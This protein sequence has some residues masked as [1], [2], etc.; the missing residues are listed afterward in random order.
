[1]IALNVQLVS[2]TESEL[3]IMREPSAFR[4]DGGAMQSG[5]QGGTSMI[6]HNDARATFG[7]GR[8]A[9]AV[10][11]GLA[12]I[13]LG[14][15]SFASGAGAAGAGAA[16]AAP[17]AGHLAIEGTGT[18]NG[19]AGYYVGPSGGL[20]SAS[21]TFTVPKV[22]CTKSDK[23]KGAI[24]YEGVYTLALDVYALVGT[25]CSSTGVSD[26]YYFSTSA[27]SFTEPGAAPGDVVV[28]SVFES[29][30]ATWAE[31][32]DLTANLYW[33]ANNPANQG[34]TAVAIGALNGTYS[35]VPVPT[36]TTVQFSNATVNGDYLGFDSPSQIN[37]VNASDSVLIAKAGKLK[38]N[39]AGSSFSVTFEHA[40]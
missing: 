3:D 40:S 26:N 30:S 14:T 6:R 25:S 20:A 8:K 2:V 9:S 35:S 29:R 28:A 21:V 31:L 39:G 36:Y 15:L 27:G 1:V 13:S 5:K 24:Q 33:V 22:T 38:T 12:A 11:A 7:W 17:R 37:T 23:N 19:L 32:H 16:G 34:D 18:S 10:V 4:A